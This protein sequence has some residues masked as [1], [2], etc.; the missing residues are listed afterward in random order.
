[1]DIIKLKYKNNLYL[2]DQFTC[3]ICNGMGPGDIK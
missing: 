2:G 3:G 1:M